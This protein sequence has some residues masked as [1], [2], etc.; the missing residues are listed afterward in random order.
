MDETYSHEECV[1]LFKTLF[2]AGFAG[3]DVLSSPPQNSMS[4]GFH[5][6]KG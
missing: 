2:P 4:A 6:A 3:A 5:A 1:S